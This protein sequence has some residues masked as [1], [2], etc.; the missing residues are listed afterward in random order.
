MI[1]L[2][3]LELIIQWMDRSD[4]GDWNVI[5]IVGIIGLGRSDLIFNG[6]NDRIWWIVIEYSVVG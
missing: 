1:R 6:G 4:W 3:R 5:F 2:G